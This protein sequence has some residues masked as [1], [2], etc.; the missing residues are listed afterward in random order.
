[1]HLLF[2][3]LISLN[4]EAGK[5]FDDLISYISKKASSTDI[6]CL[7]EVF[8]TKTSNKIVSKYYRANLFSE[9]KKILPEHTGYF[10]TLQDGFGFD[11]VCDFPIEWGDC[12][13]VKNDLKLKA[14]GE[15]FIY[16]YRN[17]R[18]DHNSTL[19]RALQYIILDINGQ[20]YVISH[21]HGLWN[22]LGKG[23]S[24]DRIKQSKKVIDFLKKQDGS[25]VL[26]GDLNL[27]PES[28]SLAIL[29]KSLVNLIKKYNIESTRSSFYKKKC[30]HASYTLVSDDII[31]KEFDVPNINVSDHLPM[32]LE[33]E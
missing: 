8:N 30:K 26:C 11:G 18:K 22:G 6:F 21:F 19:P 15:I 16:R 33:F 17:S 7:Q 32:E 28:Q 3:R 29:E 12:I 13:F 5:Y 10:T 14:K 1:M 20:N 31:V 25:K 2:L 27:L 23:D 4:V 24:A 9:L